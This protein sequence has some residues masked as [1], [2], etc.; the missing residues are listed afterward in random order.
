MDFQEQFFKERIKFIH[1]AR[2]EKEESFEKLQQQEREKVKQSNPNPS[3]AEEYRRRFPKKLQYGDIPED[4]EPEEIRPMGNHAMSITWPDG[5]SQIAPYDQLQ[6][7]E[8]LVDVPQPTAV[9]S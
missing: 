1:E 2:D 6:M 7:I 8:R 5:F 3:N 4:I 9:Q